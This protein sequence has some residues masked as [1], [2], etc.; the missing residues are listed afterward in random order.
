MKNK[1]LLFA[2]LLLNLFLLGGIVLLFFTYFFKI[3]PQI[4]SLTNELE[5][6]NKKETTLYDKD[7]CYRAYSSSKEEFV[8]I[9]KPKDRTEALSTCSK[10]F[11]KGLDPNVLNTIKTISDLEKI[12]DF[13]I[14]SCMENYGYEYN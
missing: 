13:S 3:N 7:G 10:N 5:H 8:T 9:C 2:S 14:K 4:K 1:N 12:R 6:T 11:S